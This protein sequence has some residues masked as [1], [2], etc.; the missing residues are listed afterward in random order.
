MN[1]EVIYGEIGAHARADSRML[2]RSEGNWFVVDGIQTDDA[3]GQVVLLLT[4]EES[5]D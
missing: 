3:T 1:A 2:A 5:G 4:P